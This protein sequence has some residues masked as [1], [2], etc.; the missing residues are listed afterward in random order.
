MVILHREEINSK[1]EGTIIDIET[2]GNFNDKFNDSRR[3]MNIIPIIFGY[4]NN[5]NLKIHCAKKVDSIEKLKKII[6][7]ELD[8][9]N[10][11]FYAFN[12]IFERGV[13]FHNLNIDVLFEREINK[14]RYESKKKV[15]NE[16]KIS[17]YDDPFNDN[18]KLCSEAWKKGN[19]KESIAHNR[20][21]LLKERDIL[22]KRGFR[23][24]DNLIMYE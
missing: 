18:G 15:V 3:F 7:D 1:I 2:I 5:E 20:S 22:L 8:T 4:I 9:L 19:I 23:T 11:P 21:C 12:S 6:A 24:P 14:Q 17:Q 13:L 16:L 10:E